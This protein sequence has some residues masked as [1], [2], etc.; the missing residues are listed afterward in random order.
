MGHAGAVI[1]GGKG[2]AKHK[3]EAMRDAG[4]VMTSSPAALGTTLARVLYEG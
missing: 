3:I 4:I 1:S 2:D